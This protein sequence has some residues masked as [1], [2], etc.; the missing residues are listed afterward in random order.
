MSVIKNTRGYDYNR[1]KVGIQ[2]VLNNWDELI[3]TSVNSDPVTLSTELDDIYIDVGCGLCDWLVYLMPEAD[4]HNCYEAWPYVN[5][6]Y[7]H[8]DDFP[9]TGGVEEYQRFNNKYLSDTRRQ[10]CEWVLECVEE[11]LKEQEL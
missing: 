6:L 10:L 1:V 11:Y 8:G 3:A 4:M 2:E 9:I 5:P 7:S